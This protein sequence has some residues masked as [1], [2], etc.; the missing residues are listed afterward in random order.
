MCS[1][2]IQTG[3]RRTAGVLVVGVV[4]TLAAWAALVYAAIAFGRAAG[5]GQVAPWVYLGVAA[6]GAA[7]CLVVALL[8][9][10]R[11]LSLLRGEP[12]APRRTPGKRR[13]TRQAPSDRLSG[14]RRTVR[15]VSRR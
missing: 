9:G 13:A 6:V 1:V 4:L 12:P 3:S 7:L 10:A 11:L 14:P 2:S 15:R 8:L 5:P